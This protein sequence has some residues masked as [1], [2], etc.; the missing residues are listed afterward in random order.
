M[1]LRKAS[2][3][4]LIYSDHHQSFIGNGGEAILAA[5]RYTDCRGMFFL[6]S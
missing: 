3:G 6:N 5:E 4:Q 1:L 2:V